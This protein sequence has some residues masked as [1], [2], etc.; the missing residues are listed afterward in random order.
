MAADTRIEAFAAELRRLTGLV[1]EL[2]EDHPDNEPELAAALQ[3]LA[4]VVEGAA[5]GLG[6]EAVGRAARDAESYAAGFLAGR[7]SRRQMPH[8][9][10]AG[11]DGQASLRL[12]AG[13]RR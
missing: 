12:V 9:G 4:V 3:S 13:G 5:F 2:A 10:R 8:P 11:R 7:S 1:R 6:V